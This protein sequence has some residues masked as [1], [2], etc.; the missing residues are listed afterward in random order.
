MH[1]GQTLHRLGLRAVP[2][3][4]TQLVG[5]GTDQVGQDMSVTGVTG[6]SR[7]AVA[8]AGTSGLQRWRPSYQQL[9]LCTQGPRRKTLTRLSVSDKV[10]GHPLHVHGQLDHGG[11]EAAHLA[12]EARLQAEGATQEDL[13]TADLVAVSVGDEDALEPDVRDLDA[14]IRVGAAVDGPYLIW[15]RRST[16]RPSPPPWAPL[17]PT[18]C[19][20]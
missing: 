16:T 11:F 3:D 14:G 2:S 7:D 8:L 4:G 10:A 17:R 1:P 15:T 18:P 20:R 12:T 13:E 5:M 6:G 9:L 19:A